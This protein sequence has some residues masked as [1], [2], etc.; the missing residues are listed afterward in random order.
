VT[1]ST[2]S[3]V[4]PA[5]L[6]SVG[7]YVTN[8]DLEQVR[9][10]RALAGRVTV[11]GKSGLR[12]LSKLSRDGDLWGVDLDPAGYLDREP[13]QDALF[14][15]D[16][17]ARQRELG[18][19]VIRSAGHYV[20]RKDAGAL[21]EAFSSPVDDD[22]TRVVSLDAWW[23][24][25]EGLPRLLPAIRGC[26]DHLAIVL[27]AVFDP[28]DSAGTVQGLRAFLDA[29]SPASRRV[30]LLRTDTSG[31]GFA[32]LGGALGAIGL[33]TTSRHHGLPL[34]PQAGKSY[35]ERQS[36]PLLYVPGFNSWQRGYTLGA[37]SPFGGGGVTACPCPS[38]Q[39]RDLL[40]FDQTW[41]GNVPAEV[42][43]DAMAHDLDSWLDMSRAVLGNSDPTQAWAKTCS[44]AVS[45]ASRIAE[46]FKVAVSLPRAVLDWA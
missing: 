39:G 6:R 38:C 27:A 22:T 43:A 32:A 14:A 11:A 26:D 23:L 8:G 35:D 16:W 37:L 28:F 18:L 4:A 46:T 33:T 42:R 20:P 25:P 1:A 12:V 10:V 17:I 40:R 3:I 7:A 41:P 45:T 30:E 19:P 34:G 21:R 5:R 44:D 15:L 31:V 24:R 36:S 9:R 29:A 2:S 13:E